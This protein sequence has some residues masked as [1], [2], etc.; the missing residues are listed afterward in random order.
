L[1]VDAPHQTAELGRE[2]GVVVDDEDS[3]RHSVRFIGRAEKP[4]EASGLL[5]RAQQRSPSGV[6]R[7]EQAA[8][9]GLHLLR[10]A[11]W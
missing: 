1:G 5:R 11:P 3:L 6:F 9:C 8:P 2:R 7:G 4:L 10:R